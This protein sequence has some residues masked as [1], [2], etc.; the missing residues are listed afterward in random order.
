VPVENTSKNESMNM[1][2]VIPRVIEPNTLLVEKENMQDNESSIKVE[3]IEC[4][5]LN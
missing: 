1:E 3:V 5:E 2:A 4:K